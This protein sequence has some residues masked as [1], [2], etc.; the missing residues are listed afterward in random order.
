MLAN[1]APHVRLATRSAP[2]RASRAASSGGKTRRRTS[3]PS[4]RQRSSCPA[5]RASEGG[6]CGDRGCA[7]R[8]LVVAGRKNATNSGWYTAAA[9]A[10]AIALA[11]RQVHR[12]G[13]RMVADRPGP[14]REKRWPTAAWQWAACTS[15]K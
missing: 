13:G 6:V 12:T 2:C 7:L 11:T 5:S 3:I 10:A 9:T 14:G 8:K 15:V 1:E 4:A